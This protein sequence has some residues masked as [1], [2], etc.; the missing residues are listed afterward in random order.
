MDDTEIVARWLE[1]E[2]AQ[3]LLEKLAQRIAFD[4][5]NARIQPPFLELPGY[6]MED[7][8]PVL[9]SELAL[10]IL[11]D[12]ARIKALV[13]ARDPNLPRYL[14]Q[15]FLNRCR[16]LARRSGLDP[17]RYFRK[18]TREVF[19]LSPRIHRELKDGRFL[20]F[21]LHVENEVV[22]L[23]QDF[24]HCTIE[25]PR[26][27]AESLDYSAACKEG[28]LLDL[29]V[30]F[31]SR[32]S[33]ILNGR[34]IWVDLRD[35]VKWVACYV[36]MHIGIESAE[37]EGPSGEPDSKNPDPWDLVTSG[38]QPLPQPTDEELEALAAAFAARLDQEDRAV[39]YYRFF[40]KMKW[41]EIAR[42]TG[43]KGPSG[44]SYR[45]EDA[46]AVLKGLLREWPGLSPEDEDIETMDRFWEK[47][48]AILKKTL[49]VS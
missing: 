7:V 24:E 4:L 13:A 10:F 14:H 47:L 36:P 28:N 16:D 26:R 19:R 21:S 11:E 48:R 3:R 45:F 42:R 12:R 2:A 27:L 5:G 34:R 1:T 9:R 15:A 31:W 41:G 38:V 8:L 25:L 6:H 39:F 23:P 30:H 46:K 40:E 18:R 29:A 17:W 35:F 20:M 43:F 49:P 32:L 33:G 37:G 44:P 22:R